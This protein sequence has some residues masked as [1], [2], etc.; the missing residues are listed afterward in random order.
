MQASTQ[1]AKFLDSSFGGFGPQIEVKA[2]IN[3]FTDFRDR[4]KKSKA[5]QLDSVC[6]CVSKW[7][8]EH[9]QSICLVSYQRE[10]LENKQLTTRQR[11]V[12]E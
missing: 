5:F 2:E 3:M 10:S 6:S 1:V 4:D 12:L 7:A 8:G 9:S 11:Q